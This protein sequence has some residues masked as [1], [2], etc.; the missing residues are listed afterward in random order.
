M[1]HSILTNES[2][3]AAAVVFGFLFGWLL[4]R[5][6]VTDYNVIVNQFRFKDFTVLKIMLTAVVIGGIGV[7]IMHHGG[8]A[9]THIKASPMLAIVLGSA[10]FGIGMVLYGYCPG[11]GLAACGNGSLHA[12]A[13]VGGMML[14]GIL[15]AVSFPWIA[16]HVLSVADIGKLTLN[17]LVGLPVWVVLTILTGVAGAVFLFIH[18][19]EKSGKV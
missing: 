19:L 4:Q 1:H 8:L 5:G 10:I 9:N 14:G 3:L 11:T 18:K 2:L 16:K 7:A 12:L 6:G 17:E 15:Y 13:G